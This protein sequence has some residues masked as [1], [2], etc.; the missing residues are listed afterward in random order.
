MEMLENI[1]TLGIE[2]SLPQEVF[3]QIKSLQPQ[4]LPLVETLCLIKSPSEMAMIR[5]AA[6][7]ADLGMEKI[8][9]VAYDGVSEIEI[10]S[11]NRAIQMKIIKE[12]DFD[13]ST[14]TCS[15]QPDLRDWEPSPTVS[16]KSK[17]AL[18]PDPI[19]P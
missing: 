3:L 13:P 11:Q 7:Y 10:F 12:T 19:L 18:K 6:H 5:Q 14:P 4:T 1:K 8:L 15:L 16:P 2:P 17:N 9:A